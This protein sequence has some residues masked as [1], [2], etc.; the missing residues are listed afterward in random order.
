MQRDRVVPQASGMQLFG[1]GYVT[2]A[3]GGNTE[4]LFIAGGGDAAQPNGNLASVDT[5]GNNL[6]PQVLGTLTA[7]SDFS[8][9]L[10]GTNEAKLYGFYPVITTGPSY[11]QEID[12]TSGAPV[13]MQWNLGATGL[14]NQI[15]DWA[16]AQWGGTF[17]IFVTTDDGLGNVSSTVRSVDRAT[18]T[19]TIILQGLPYNIDGAGVSTCAP[20]VVQ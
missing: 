9:E 15:R 12:K 18:S 8:P 1:M 20:V 4:H 7:P 2:D 19:Y 3:M 14:G 13:G 16:F 10:T 11:V 6:T 5:H 17:Y